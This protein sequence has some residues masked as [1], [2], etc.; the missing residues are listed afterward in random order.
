MLNLSLIRNQLL[1][2]ESRKQLGNSPDLVSNITDGQ[3]IHGKNAILIQNIKTL[4]VENVQSACDRSKK[5]CSNYLAEKLHYNYSY[6]AYLFSVATGSTIQQYI[7]NYKIAQVKEM[8]L[9]DSINL[10]QISY[11]LNYSSVAHLSFQFKKVTGLT[12][13]LFKK[14]KCNVLP[15]MMKSD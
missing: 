14:L 9:Y 2:S 8:L 10:T 3:P 6:L 13:T 12:P 11:K 15:R 4:I 5:N 7:I 1:I